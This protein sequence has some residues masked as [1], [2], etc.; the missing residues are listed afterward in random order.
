MLG[1]SSVTLT[2]FLSVAMYIINPAATAAAADALHLYFELN[3]YAF[4]QPNWRRQ[5]T[6]YTKYLRAKYKWSVG[7]QIQQHEAT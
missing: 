1:K 6:A 4:Y 5:P 3:I 7:R 2:N